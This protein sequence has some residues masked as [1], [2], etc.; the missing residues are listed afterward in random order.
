MGAADR[1]WVRVGVGDTADAQGPHGEEPEACKARSREGRP[2]CECC[3]IAC[4]HPVSETTGSAATKRAYSPTPFFD[5]VKRGGDGSQAEAE[6]FDFFP[7]TFSLP[8]EGALFTRAFKE[9]GG[10]WIM[11]PVGRAQGKGIFLVNKLSQ[12]EGWLKVLPR[13]A[14]RRTKRSRCTH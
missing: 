3:C 7:L 4:P 13:P 2:P 1:P 5:G 11:K 9:H 6:E 14:T 10:V 8:G 12:I